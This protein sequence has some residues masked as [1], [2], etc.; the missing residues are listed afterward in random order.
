MGDL[1]NLIIELKGMVIHIIVDLKVIYL[2]RELCQYLGPIDRPVW[3]YC[4]AR[5]NPRFPSRL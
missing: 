2:Q 5:S 1:K 4:I 3:R